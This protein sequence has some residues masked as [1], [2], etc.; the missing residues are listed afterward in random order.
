MFQNWVTEAYKKKNV[1]YF[2]VNDYRI[3]P[4]DEFS[5]N[6]NLSAKYRVKRSGSAPVGSRDSIQEVLE[7][8]KSHFSITGARIDGKKL[9]VSS[10]SELHGIRFVIS[11]TEYM[12]SKRG[13][14]FE[15]RRLSNTFNANVIFSVSLKYPGTDL[16][17]NFVQK[18]S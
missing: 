14:E 6:F 18:L 4:L 7:Y 5:N 10:N 17:N 12:L 13:S 2:I 11:D 9:F 15:V 8:V 3:F 16:R 1:K